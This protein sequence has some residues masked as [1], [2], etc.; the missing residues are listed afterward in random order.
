MSSKSEL[1]LYCFVNVLPAF[2]ISYNFA[3]NSNFFILFLFII[4]M[5]YT[6]A[7]VCAYAQRE[8]DRHG[9]HVHVHGARAWG[10]CMCMLMHTAG[11]CMCSVRG[12]TASSSRAQVPRP[13]RQRDQR[14]AGGRLWPAHVACVSEGARVGGGMGPGEGGKAERVGM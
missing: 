1:M 7:I 2:S 10:A 6:S 5:I 12:L 9:A 4:Q 14:A 3:N 13:A 8:R 11:M